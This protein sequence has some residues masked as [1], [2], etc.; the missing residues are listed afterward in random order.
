MRIGSPCPT[1]ASWV[2]DYI[3]HVDEMAY[4]CDFVAFHAY[5]GSNEAPSIDSWYNQLKA[6]YDATGR[7][8]WL[9][10]FNNGASWTKET[11]PSYS[12]NGEKMKEIIQMLEDA[13]FIERYC[14]YNW[15]DWHLAVL[16]WDND[17]KSWWVNPAGQAYRDVKPHFAYNAKMQ[18][19]PNWWGF[20]LKKNS[21]ELALEKLQWHNNKTG[22]L[23]IKNANIDQTDELTLECQKE[24]GSWTLFRT[25]DE[26]ELFDN[27]S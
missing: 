19:V 14:I 23:S 21:D 3:K 7:P 9:T 16:T 27:S 13:P 24:D 6:I 15:D 4:R 11:K 17:K 12:A 5:W 26:R 25:I 1:D 20:D 8:I 2:K 10:E 22:T 18:K